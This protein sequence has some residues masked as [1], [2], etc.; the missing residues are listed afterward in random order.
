MAKARDYYEVMG[1]KRDATEKDIKMAYRR[2]ARKYHPDISKEADA[3]E[4]FKELGQAY[5]V[6]K[7]PEKRKAYDQF[8]HQDPYSA[9][10]PQQQYYYQQA[11]SPFGEGDF[12]EDI[13][14]SIFG[15][16]RPKK[17]VHRKGEDFQANIT[18]T[19]EEA[20][21]GT[22][23]QIEL[24]VY[25]TSAQ[26]QPEITTRMLNVKIPAGAKEGQK[27]RLQGQGGPG[28]NQGPP[29]DLYL[30]V[31]FHKHPLYEI[32]NQDIWLTLPVTPWEAAL[33][34][35]LHVPT[36][37]G[38]VDL[39]IPKGSQGGQKLRLKGRGFP[40][41]TAGDQ[42]IV[43]KI[44]I[45]QPQTDAA[46]KLYQDMASQMPFNPRANMGV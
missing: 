7:D 28:F 32:R 43:L 17:P 8:G 14:A 44:V 37:G 6:L 42:I 46:V 15:H 20:W 18:L 35:T 27:I 19:L 30:T 41:K 24:P 13:L 22:E 23:R 11:G 25:T 40:G 31:H 36:L 3:E 21:K 5:E 2:L 38:R 26:G 10:R 16:A 33:G 34:A 4:K 29:G 45:P 12:D 9:Q 1:L 39:K